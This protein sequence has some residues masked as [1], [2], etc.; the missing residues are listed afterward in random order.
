MDVVIGPCAPEATVAELLDVIAGRTPGADP[1]GPLMVDVDGTPVPGDTRLADL[2][3]R[4][5]S[6]LR[7]GRPG[8]PPPRPGPAGP[9]PG[10]AE[11]RRIAGPDAGE[12]LVL[13]P[14][15]YLI[16][17]GGPGGLIPGRARRPVLRLAVDP[18]SAGRIAAVDDHSVRVDGADLAGEESV[19][20]TLIVCGDTVF[21][22]AP[23][24]P[25]QPPLLSR[26]VD[27][28]GRVPL[29][30]TPRVATPPPSTAVPVPAPPAPAAVAAPMSWLL[31][32]AP[33]PVG[34]VMAL[35][36]S[37]FFL[38]MTV[39][40]PLMG[41]A[42]WVESKWN[43]RKDAKRLAAASAA[44]VRQFTDD[45]EARREHLGD[46]ARR[47]YAD[48]AVLLRRARSGRGLWQVRPGDDD[49]MCVG[50][51]FGGRSWQPDLG[52]RGADA[53]AAL[54]ALGDV[55][56]GRSSLADVPI[57]L[58]LRDRTGFGVIGRDDARRVV[59]SVVLDL[60]TRHG[61]A[62][63][64]LVLLAEPD[65]LA[66][67]D[68][69]KWLPH[70][71]G[72]SF[73]PRVAADPAAAADLLAGL[74]A[75]TGRPTGLMKAN[76][77][78]QP[79]HLV[80]VV[81][82]A[83]LLTGRIAALLGRL[84]AGRGRVL[85]VA[86]RA[87]ELPSMCQYLLEIGDA[88]TARLTDAVTG[89]VQHG[90]VAVQAGPAIREQTARALARWTDPEQVTAA[91]VLPD[92]ARL[93]D[94]LL[95]EA[96]GADGLA[97]PVSQLDAGAVGDWWRRGSAGL[98]ATFGVTEQGPLALDLLADG[99]HGLV[100]GT[101]GAGKSELLRTLV[102]SMACAY[103]PDVL[104]FMLVDFKGG[105]AFDACASLPHTVGLVTDLDE[106]LAARALRC[107][108]AE[109]R[110]R[111]LRLR[112]AGVS[113]LRDYLA[114]DP[115]LPRLVIVIDEFA[116]LAV[117]LPGFLSA[118]IDVAQ[119]GRSLGIHLL[120]AT[121]RPQ[122]VV[123]GKIRA[124]TNLRVALRVQDDADSR[125]VLGT[126]QAADIDR[127][128]PGRAYVRLG[129]GEVVA[130][131]TALVS[132]GGPGGPGERISVSPFTLISPAEPGEARTE[133]GDVPTDLEHI[134]AVTTAAAEAGGYD[135]PR[136][137]WPPSL[138]GEVDGWDL[139]DAVAD[140]EPVP[141][142]LVDL[143]DE[144]RSDVW[145]WRPEEGGTA[146]LGADAAATAAVLAAACVGLAR[147]R[148]P[149]RQRI[150]VLDGQGT[151]FAPLAGLP[152]VGAVVGAHDGERLRRVLDHLDA[153]VAQ[154]RSSGTGGPEILVVVAGW[155]ALTE[156]AERAGLADAEQR[157]ERLLRDGGPVG[158]RLM[159][160]VPHDRG[161]PARVLA[162][163]PTKLC[164]RLADAGSYT[165]LGLRPRDMPELRGLR[166]VETASR[167]EIQIGRYDVAA[168]VTRVAAA[169]PGTA[170]APTV[171]VLPDVV[172]AME[173]L[174]ASGTAG[175]G[176]RLGVGRNYHDLSIATLSLAPGMHAIVAGPPGSGRTSALRML[177]MA[178]TAGDPRATVCV[179]AA[180]PAAWAGTTVDQL[181]DSFDTLTRWPGE[182]RSLLLVDGIE[183]LG[184]GAAATLDR[185]IGAVPAG[186]YVVVAGRTEAFRGMQ[187]WQRA[188]SMSRTGLLLRPSPDDGDVLRIR[189]PREAAPRPVPGRGYLVEAGGPVQIQT[190]YPGPP[191]A[192]TTTAPDASLLPAVCR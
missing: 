114:P 68:W 187:P 49:E 137:P 5:G 86:E 78:E 188:V 184:P 143:P 70:L 169:Y 189:L 26:P 15:E 45:L 69:A 77:P 73:L 88:G 48:L 93:L 179:V 11:L 145:W 146:V 107:L 119:R 157:L 23:A 158:L 85:V 90:L 65:R 92:R 91:A 39:M 84:S 17:R 154:R 140:G 165:G 100:V 35:V 110:H 144:Q 63:L 135:P 102:A 83:R 20:G 152:H 79:A 27:S 40:T 178:A 34:I 141:L 180:D 162:Q 105:G 21:R 32:L 172:P 136:V 148:P 160:S 190:A 123:D 142:G 59:S 98:R 118:L 139:P 3:A 175:A 72:D 106:H 14:G 138:P 168:A 53:L 122:G 183:S 7:L 96:S 133:P 127:R 46:A 57:N 74:D 109:L 113:D 9:R 31:M 128:R 126:R 181:T 60:V 4:C 52:R 75:G 150:F 6:V 121:Q 124:N 159:V 112:A 99:P 182:G 131:Q 176:W 115:P 117:E 192:G 51:G 44:A 62:D 171:A 16:G 108:R 30:R 41:L 1:G 101:T 13:P 125:D 8:D 95:A 177:A 81:D 191:A 164:L 67:W 37:P 12:A 50:V 111:E 129:A 56:A 174:S 120:L 130:V 36:F 97:R 82:G 66:D 153:E 161:M 25:E 71:S 186:G 185:L 24:E 28:T 104:T 29:V 89:E 64:E 33:L 2:P 156:A 43:A 76:T 80:L 163:M 170:P 19:P 47:E 116:T 155:A 22:L 54:P 147:I 42:R 149:R 38:L 167:N 166:A 103:S 87:E 132:A 58:N 173:V 10:S 61:P 18:G 94:L 55:L 134:V 151:A